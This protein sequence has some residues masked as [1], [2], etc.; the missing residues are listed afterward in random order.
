MA[1]R[2]TRP[3]TITM[4]GT[5]SRTD[6]GGFAGL[7][8]LNCGSALEVIQPGQD[9][10]ERLLGVCPRSCDRCG[11]WHIINADCGDGQAVIALVPDGAA[12]RSA[13]ELAE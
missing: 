12:F 10:P 1:W 9:L 2:V 6:P 3:M 4:W 7:R 8:C 11:S 13:Y 5:L